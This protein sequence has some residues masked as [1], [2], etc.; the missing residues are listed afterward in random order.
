MNKTYH[1]VNYNDPNDYFAVEASNENDAAFEALS[2]LG[3]GISTATRSE[4][5]PNQY[6][7][8]FV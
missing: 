4:H 3:Y 2:Q 8:D 7:F 5:D 1:I 6:E